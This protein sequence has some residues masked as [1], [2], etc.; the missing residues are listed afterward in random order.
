MAQWQTAVKGVILATRERRFLV[1]FVIAFLIF[2]TIMNLLAGGTA[3]VKLLF[4][5]SFSVLAK[6][7]LGLFG[8]G[9]SF[10]D[11]ILVFLISLL[12]GV[13]IGLLALVWKTRK[14]SA[15]LQNTGIVAGLAI[16]GTGCPTCG[17]TLLAPVV[18][19]VVG[20]G[21][22]AIAGTVSGILTGAAVVVALFA[23]KKLGMEAY[24]IMISKEKK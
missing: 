22:L 1:A 16:L 21:G 11:W 3:G 4:N 2:G 15:D 17:T 6:A 18:G 8:V 5:G 13:L 7:F 20:G 24:G 12:Q 10:V 14:D 19:A 9:M 23:L